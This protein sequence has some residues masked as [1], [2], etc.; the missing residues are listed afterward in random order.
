MSDISQKTSGFVRDLGEAARQ[1]PLSAALIGMGVLWL[2][3]GGR[4]ERAGEFVRRSGFDQIPDEADDA[5]EA[6]RSTFRSG[7]VATGERVGSAKDA[8]RDGGAGALDSATRLGRDY[9]DTASEYMSSMP[10]AGAEMFGTLRSNLT[11]V[12]RAQPLALG[13]IGLALGA[14]IAAALPSS[15]LEAAYLGETSDIVKA[16]AAEFASEQATRATKVAGNVMDAVTE[17]ARRQRLT[18]EDAKSAVGNFSAKVG[19]VV[20]A[21]GKGISE[22]EAPSPKAK[23]QSHKPA[24]HIEETARLASSVETAKDPGK[25][26]KTKD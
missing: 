25:V 7:A 4:M 12:F 2:F 6:A 15:E 21:A 18:V 19:R 26:R 5:F 3:T 13:A 16:N 24:K 20:D 8:Q 1:N 10:G 14:G 11:D 23:D 9:A 22:K 17:E